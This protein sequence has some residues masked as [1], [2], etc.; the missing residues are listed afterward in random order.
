M[1]Y[2][3]WDG[4]SVSTGDSSYQL[5]FC[6]FSGVNAS[7]LPGLALRNGI[8]S[9]WNATW[10]QM[11]HSG[12]YTS[13]APSLTGG[14][15]SGTWGISIS[16]NAATSTT[17]T[18]ANRVLKASE[19]DLNT[20]FT[21]TPAGQLSWT[22][23]Y[24]QTNAPT[25]NTYYNTISMRH[26]NVSNVYGNQFSIRWVD[27]EPNTY[28]R[29]VNNNVFGP[30]RTILTDFNYTSY[31]VPIGGATLDNIFYYRTNL[32]PYLG[33]LN[34]ARLQ[35]YNTDGGSAFMSFHKSGLYAVNF[36]LD[37][38]NV[39][40]IG[41]WSASANRWQLDMSGNQTVAGTST[42]TGFFEGSDKRFKQLIQDD[43]R[44]VGVQNI[45]PK[46]Y[47]KDGKEEVGYF[48]QDF[49]SILASAVSENKEGFLNL[50]YTQVHTA[51]IAIIEDEVTILKRRI[52]ELESKLN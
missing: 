18:T 46:L 4:T 42:A 39:M 7:G 38:D 50:S 40:R 51:K 43:Y 10:Y 28:V 49:H 30:W 34:S 47:I 19:T 3:P 5:A 52:A 35:V 22:E 23:E 26:G 21:N 11:L 16:G 15:A 12:N 33:T 29:V 17:A 45:K 32:G 2:A 31:A 44:A 8:N 24:N 27:P 13:Y 37:T 41:G 14:G 6:N 20:A 25:A 36:G 1:T 48:A 9:G